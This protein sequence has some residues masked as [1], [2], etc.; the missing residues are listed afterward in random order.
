MHI[1]VGFFV[2]LGLLL[3]VPLPDACGQNTGKGLG[4][5]YINGFSFTELRMPVP[6]PY[7]PEYTGTKSLFTYGKKG[8]NPA[9]GTV[10]YDYEYQLME[11]PRQVLDWY[12]SVLRQN[13]WTMSNSQD[14]G[15]ELSAVKH[16]EGCRVI[17]SVLNGHRKG[18]KTTLH[19]GYKSYKPFAEEED[20]TKSNNN[21]Y[22]PQN[23]QQQRR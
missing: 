9:K 12:R 22:R 15:T 23:S 8:E 5:S 10:G 20:S 16:K 19:I 7:L 4:T 17:V 1:K 13:R 3:A 6:L 21:A 14:A 2:A 11:D 18:Y